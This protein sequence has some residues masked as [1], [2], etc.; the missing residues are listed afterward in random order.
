MGLAIHISSMFFGL[1]I[2][3]SIVGAGFITNALFDTKDDG[4]KRT[5][6][7]TDI[8]L[9]MARISLILYMLICAPVIYLYLKMVSK[10]S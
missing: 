4:N 3:I 5:I 2:M 9:T 8:Q 7:L 6:S 1:F 10:S